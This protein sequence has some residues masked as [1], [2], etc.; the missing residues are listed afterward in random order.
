MSEPTLCSNKSP[1]RH[2]LNA[3]AV[4]IEQL[5][6]FSRQ[7]RRYPTTQ[8]RKLA[9]S[10]DA[11]GFVLPIVIDEKDQVVGGWALVLATKRLGLTEVPAVTVTHLSEV[12]LRALRLAL[13]R[14]SDDGAW[15][16]QELA[17]ELK[18]LIDLGFEIDLTGFEIA[19]IDLLIEEHGGALGE[20]HGP[21]DAVVEP[22]RD[23]PA[24]TKPGDVWRLGEHL[25]L[26]G[27]A[28]DP[29]SY[30]VLLCGEAP[31]LVFT[32]PPYNVP[33]VGHASGLGRI[34]HGNF[35]MAAG[36]M[37]DDAY[38]EFLQSTLSRMA[39]ALVDGSIAF[40]CIDWRHVQQAIQASK[41]VG[42]TLKNICVWVKTNGGMGTF[43]R[44]R[45][46]FV[47]VLKEGD[48]PHI[49]TF[50][51]GDT[52]RY[53][54]NVWEYAGVNAFGRERLEELAMHP[55]VKPTALVADA[56]KDCSW[57]RDLVL[58]PFAGS[59]TT[60][61]AAE[62]TGRR[63]RAIEIDPHYCDVIIRRWQSY[64][65]KSAEHLATRLSFEDMEAQRCAG[66]EKEEVQT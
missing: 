29:E 55:T 50:G 38:V 51:L 59:G 66:K 44:S 34:R 37:S 13:N 6:P 63:A 58:D 2:E 62:K 33:I 15:D 23:R 27:D 57:R 22:N 7:V 17:F 31:R 20:E 42:F 32:D 64:S 3:R 4:A 19:E 1:F 41:L 46:E 16:K 25:L 18:E 61:I 43:Y 56:L 60:I 26:C 47:L 21:E 49:N 9:K 24:V 14:L 30:A 35:A 53:R 54:T 28:L 39:D 40:V 8:I 36:E 65:G 45:H 10:V 11:F 48:S 52:G 12:E 5:R